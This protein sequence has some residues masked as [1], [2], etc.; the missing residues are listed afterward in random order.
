MRKPR[1]Y[2][3]GVLTVD[4]EVQLS[5]EASHHLQHVLRVHVDHPVVLFNGDG[6][7]YAGIVTSLQKKAIRIM[8]TEQL[9][10]NTESPLSIHLAQVISRGDKM[11]FSLQ[12]AVELGVSSIT[13]IISERCNVRL[14]NDR[15]QKKLQHWQRVIIA[16][17]EQSGRSVLPHLHDILS[18]EDFAKQCN[19]QG[20]NILF[21]PEASHSF[22]TLIQQ[23]S[24]LRL[25]IGCEGGFSQAEVSLLTQHHHFKCCSLGPRIFRTET[26]GLVALSIAQGLAGDL[27]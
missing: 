20:I 2:H 8:M 25:L 14:A 6:Y 7:N 1:I 10:N 5:A 9:A 26:A 4:R 24:V 3:A 15:Q 13:P 17:C 18:L 19:D 21:H 23:Q 16:A 27:R 11:D 12:K 22:A